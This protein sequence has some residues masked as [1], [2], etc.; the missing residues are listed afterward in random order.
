MEKQRRR[1]ISEKQRQR[2]R[3]YATANSQIDQRSIAQWASHEFDRTVTQSMISRSLSN[4]YAY[5]DTKIFQ[6]REKDG[7]K[8]RIPVSTSTTRRCSFRLGYHHGVRT[9]DR[10]G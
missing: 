4:T 5:L 1:P 3:Q 9:I 2:I 7:R 10:N 6:K 8:R